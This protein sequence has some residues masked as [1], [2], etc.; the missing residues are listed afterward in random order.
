MDSGFVI[1]ALFYSIIVTLIIFFMI[2]TQKFQFV[3]NFKFAKNL[4]V[5]LLGLILVFSG[6][7]IAVYSRIYISGNW[8]PSTMPNNNH[9]LV[10]KGPYSFI[11]HPLYFGVVLALAGNAIILAGY[12]NMIF[13]IAF[14]FLLF[15]IHSEEKHLKQKYGLL[16]QRYKKKVIL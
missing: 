7:A 11:R 16:Y 9:E 5:T 2:Y 8:S 1:F 13:F 4:I 3:Y 14:V 12:W 10:T 15:K 6:L